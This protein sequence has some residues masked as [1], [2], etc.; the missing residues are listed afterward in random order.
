MGCTDDSWFH[1]THLSQR[2][3]YNVA[4]FC[5]F[6]S[7]FCVYFAGLHNIVLLTTSGTPTRLLV[8]DVMLSLWRHRNYNMNHIKSINHLCC[9]IRNAVFSTLQYVCIGP[10]VDCFFYIYFYFN[11]N[12]YWHFCSEIFSLYERVNVQK[13]QDSCNDD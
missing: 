12:F 4:K 5:S 3:L 13:A 9:I 6:L 11:W 2:S 1:A 8:L 10:F 7:Y